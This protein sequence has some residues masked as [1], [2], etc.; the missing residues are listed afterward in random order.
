MEHDFITKC[1]LDH[2]NN[3]KRYLSAKE[4][5]ELQMIKIRA[6]RPHDKT[7]LL[8]PRNPERGLY[9]NWPRKTGKRL[10]LEAMDT[11]YGKSRK[12][13]EKNPEKFRGID[14]TQFLYRDQYGRFIDP[15][16]GIVD[17]KELLK[18][19]EAAIP[20]PLPAIHGH[21]MIYGTGGEVSGGEYFNHMWQ[22]SLKKE[23]QSPIMG[24]GWID[25]FMRQPEGVGFFDPVSKRHIHK[26]FEDLG[27]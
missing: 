16:L 8:K 20:K 13:I 3:A 12:P 27:L 21:V 19:W 26:S 6:H 22:K 18:A 25:F 11:F 9:L 5:F 7:I 4:Y 1:I 24:E 17:D 2:F 23:N 10:A 14:S 15:D